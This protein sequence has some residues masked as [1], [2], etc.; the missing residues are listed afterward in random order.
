MLSVSTKNFMHLINVQ[1]RFRHC[2]R[3]IWP[4]TFFAYG[5]ILHGSAF[6]LITWHVLRYIWVDLK[7][8]DSV[9]PRNVSSSGKKISQDSKLSKALQGHPSRLP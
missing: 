4:S 8:F 7:W 9:S 6:L 3:G 5:I 1:G 2:T